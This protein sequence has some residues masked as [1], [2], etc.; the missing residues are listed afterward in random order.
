MKTK[1]MLSIITSVLLLSGCGGGGG[2]GAVK[3][4]K[5]VGIPEG[6]YK[7]IICTDKNANDQ[8]CA[9]ASV[10][11]LSKESVAILE[12]PEEIGAS[13]FEYF[14]GKRFVLVPKEENEISPWHMLAYG[15]YLYAQEKGDKWIE[16][17]SLK[18]PSSYAEALEMLEKEF[19]LTGT[20]AQN[21]AILEAFNANLEYLGQ[22]GMPLDEAA[23]ADIKAMA[24]SL[25]NL[26]VKE[27]A[28]DWSGLGAAGDS[29]A[30]CV[31]EKYGTCVEW[32]GAGIS[33]LKDILGDKLRINSHQAAQIAAENREKSDKPNAIDQA[34]EKLSCEDTESKQIY[35]F[36]V[37]D[38]FD[39]SNTEP[40]HPGT[41]LVNTMSGMNL[42]I[43]GYDHEV[44]DFDHYYIFLETLSGLP[45]NITQGVFAIGLK[46]TGYS[47]MGQTTQYIDRYFIANNLSMGL[48]DAHEGNI[49]TLRATWDSPVTDIYTKDLSQMQTSS[50]QNLL[51][52]VQAGQTL[53]TMIFFTTNVD[54]MAVAACVPKSKP[55]EPETPIK[56][57]PVKLQCNVEK[58]EH[59]VTVWGGTSDDFAPGTDVS[60]PSTAL[61]ALL[62]TT[63]KYDE[64]IKEK[65]GTFADTLAHPNAHVT[66]M[67]L[68]VN[69]RPSA[70]GSTDDRIFIGDIGASQAADPSL[71]SGILTPNG[72][73]AILVYGGE[74]VYNNNGTA[75]GNLLSLVNGGSDLDIII[76]DQTEVDVT[77]LSMCI[78]EEE[79]DPCPSGDSD[80]DGVCDDVDCDPKDPTIWTGCDDGNETKTCG[81]KMSINLSQAS[82]WVNTNAQNPTVHN[83]FE[84][85]PPRPELAG[86]IWDGDLTWF[87]FGSQS[88]AIHELSM[89]F[90]ACGTT[91][92]VISEFKSDNYGKMYLDTDPTPSSYTNPS[93]I[94]SR[95]AHSQTTMASWGTSESG[96]LHVPYSGTA[97]D[98]TLN[99]TVKNA[100]GPSGGAVDGTLDFIGHLGA[101]TPADNVT[102]P[103]EDNNTVV[104]NTDNNWTVTTSTGSVA[105]ITDIT[106]NP[107]PDTP[108]SEDNGTV[109]IGIE[110][111]L[112]GTT[113]NGKPFID[114]EPS[115][116]V[117][118]TDVGTLELDPAVLVLIDHLVDPP[119]YTRDPDTQIVTDD[120]QHLEWQDDENASLVRKPW[121]TSQSNTAEDYD[122]TSGDTAST[123]CENLT[124]GT[125]TD[126]RLPTIDELRGI[127]DYNSLNPSIDI[128]EFFN[129]STYFYQTS[130]SYTTS[131][132]PSNSNTMWVINFRYG[133]EAVGGKV[134]PY[135]FVRC[136]RAIP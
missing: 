133:T 92:V 68:L 24:E 129:T 85:Y 17:T 103:T 124:L 90:C 114:H 60:T 56:D 96:L 5:S 38:V 16:I 27:I 76:G 73:T 123:Y 39:P 31:R 15:L 77:R 57:I 122:N 49:S 125:H 98:H 45:S 40:A 88:G 14:K 128:S 41:A 120:Q 89:D 18:A 106:W 28:A 35:M 101:C 23:P 134:D 80:G 26:T 64:P 44:T 72:G 69:T 130:T 99:M 34:F 115:V 118:I 67:Q 112:V 116:V 81:E 109:V 93:Y 95:S 97:T 59:L 1:T 107:I 55:T 131:F 108:V 30:D 33:T 21:R 12:A 83:E 127:V 86:R 91:D 75:V 58:G 102:V 13:P 54:F 50:G 25:V 135:I 22:Q 10:F 51:S 87:N 132:M 32:V 3:E 78:V 62:G 47:P 65:S 121:I 53:D 4:A 136:V 84:T 29:G 2:A 119:H 43:D 20:E 9:D 70:A 110:G 7:T 48:S 6:K 111:P 113:P 46:E 63:L 42:G 104:V 126:W 82:T 105:V 52:K 8:A 11:D 79:P 74:T 36:G 100:S 66:Q 19:G 117:N 61:S 37:Y 71:T 94:V